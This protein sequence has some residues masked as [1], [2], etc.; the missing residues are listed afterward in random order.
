MSRERSRPAGPG[1]RRL[2]HV[3]GR[4]RRPEKLNA[5]QTLVS[6]VLTSLSQIES[7]INALTQLI[8]AHLLAQIEAHFNDEELRTLCF[9]LEIEYEDLPATTRTGRARELI[10]YCQRENQ[11]DRLVLAMRRERPNLRL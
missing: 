8:L 7:Q 10:S 1:E 4:Y 3:L 6:A 11:V 5:G 2:R 9:E